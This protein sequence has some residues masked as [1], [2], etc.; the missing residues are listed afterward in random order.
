[1]FDEIAKGGPKTDAFNEKLNEVKRNFEAVGKT[2]LNVFIKENFA[3][4]TA[5]AKAFGKRMKDIASSIGSSFKKAF[6]Y[7]KV[8][9]LVAFGAISAYAVKAVQEWSKEEKSVRN[10]ANAIEQHG[11]SADAVVPKLQK[12]ADAIE[13]ETAVGGDVVQQ[14]MASLRLLGVETDKL[15]DASRAVIGLTKA[16]MGEEGA[17][18]AV[19]AARAGD[20]SMLTRYIPALRTA[21]TD[22]EK[23]TIVNEFVTKQYKAQKDELNTLTGRYAELKG[24]IG[25]FTEA[26]GRAISENLFLKDAMAQ[27]SARIK[28]LVA[29]G[30]IKEWVDKIIASG[31]QLIQWGMQVGNVI[32]GILDYKF[33][34]FWAA[35]AF[36]LTR[37][38]IAA[39]PAIKNIYNL[40]KA[41]MVYNKAALLSKASGPGLQSSIV[42]AGVAGAAAIGTLVV[43][44]VQAYHAIKQL[45]N[46]TDNLKY[47]SDKMFK[48]FGTR[49]A[50]A[51]RMAKEMYNSGD[52]QK[53]A[54]IERMYPKIVASIKK[55]SDA[56]KELKTEQE[57]LIDI[58]GQAAEEPAK[59]MEKLEDATNNT[60]RAFEALK[61]TVS[62]GTGATS[63]FDSVLEGMNTLI[64]GAG[65]MK[66]KE[67][68]S[69]FPKISEY[70]KDAG[71][72]TTNLTNPD[73]S[74]ATGGSNQI[75][76]ATQIVNAIQNQTDILVKSLTSI[77]KSIGNMAFVL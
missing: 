77:D 30:K 49:N 74:N 59:E 22:A 41:L 66:M 5:K 1:M 65:T 62:Q 12:Y 52:P 15:D 48:D 72:I 2:K 56:T 46:A 76:I 32:K 42:G 36:Q 50:D 16:G 60:Q 18:R 45:D 29:S 13:D 73:L 10:L 8:K 35:V 4:L 75:S 43:V 38:G 3:E 44:A 27:L 53:M 9:A 19:A 51:F 54:T 40:A 71:E 61:K 37:F 33:E 28:E 20:V 64:G 23:A 17:L 67:M 21:K 6:K 63:I 68:A 14:R 69:S 57:S 70:F 26:V 24:R 31:K 34:I 58:V 7:I 39:I 55:T 47:T 11:E 25:Q